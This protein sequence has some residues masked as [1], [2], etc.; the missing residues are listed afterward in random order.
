[1][2]WPQSMGSIPVRENLRGIMDRFTEPGS[3]R[4]ALN[5]LL[6]NKGGDFQN[7]QFTSDTVVRVERRKQLAKGYEVHIWE[8]PVSELPDCTDLVNLECDSVE[9]S[10]GD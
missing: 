10:H 1:M 5:S 7:S 2:W 9:F 4:D 8:R 3:F 6:M